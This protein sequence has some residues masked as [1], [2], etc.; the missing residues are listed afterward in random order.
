MKEKQ[1]QERQNSIKGRFI[2]FSAV[3]FLV[4]FIGG[5]ATF[6]FSMW[7]I[8]HST[9]GYEL[10]QSMELERSKL[11][12]SVNSEIA[13]ALKMATSPPD[14]APLPQSNRQRT[15]KNRL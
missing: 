3:L 1:T 15:K 12:A 13:I 11:E 5:S 14:T 2:I 4:I 7:Q 9:A 6:V 10:S 8:L